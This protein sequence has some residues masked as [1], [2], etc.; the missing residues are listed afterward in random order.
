M[1]FVVTITVPR[2][3]ESTPAYWHVRVHSDASGATWVRRMMPI[4]DGYGAFWFARDPE[5]IESEPLL[6]AL[7]TA[8]APALQAVHDGIVGRRPTADVAE[9]GRYLFD[10]LIGDTIWRAI[11]SEAAAAHEDIELALCWDWSNRSLSRL[12]WEMMATADQFLAGGYVEGTRVHE[13]AVTRVVPETPWAGRPARTVPRILF[14]VGTSLL[15]GTIRAGS[16]IIDILQRPGRESDIQWQLIEEASPSLVEQHVK[17]FAPDVVHFVC[18][19]GVDATSGEG[20]LELRPDP[21]RSDSQF[22]A[23]QI[24]TWLRAAGSMPAMVVLSACESG[25]AALGP[26]HMSPLAAALVMQGTPVVIG[27]SGRISDLA[28]RLFTRRFAQA[29]IGA[30]HPETLVKATALGRRAAFAM[31]NDPRASV[32]WGFPTVFLSS[33]VNHAYTPAVAPPTGAV[34]VESRLMPYEL[35]RTP[36]FCGRREFFDAFRELMRDGTGALVAFVDSERKGFGRTRLLEALTIAGV[37]EG[38]IPCLVAAREGR[39]RAPRDAYELGRLVDEA[40]ETARA[41]LA[42]PTRQERPWLQLEQYVDGWVELQALPATLRRALQKGTRPGDRVVTD[43]AVTVAL[44]E[45][46]AALMQTARALRPNLIG[47]RSRAVVL[48]DDVHDYIDVLDK[49]VGDKLGTFGFGSQS[50]DNEAGQTTGGPVPIVFTLSTPTARR[51]FVDPIVQGRTGVRAL[52][53]GP[54]RREKGFREDM[55]VYRRFLLHTAMQLGGHHEPVP[56]VMDYD[57]E[58]AIVEKYE[59]RYEKWLDAIPADLEDK[60]FRMI[61]DEASGDKF[62]KAADDAALVRELQKERT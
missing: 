7:S 55:L 17:E 45:Q 49:V 42:L 19:G 30:D 15:D 20:F 35:R 2:D 13:V 39:W 12:H 58:K 54:F 61:S 24:A 16:E 27:M 43:A 31:G 46:L 14:V 48:L 44:E 6:S 62:L 1:R 29:L 38:H 22:G 51:V 3:T 5:S 36:V 10:V 41:S 59:Q 56:W 52:K 50:I 28:C 25:G 11:A 4:D 26:H 33:H 37:M 32:D 18:H 40:M 57:V 60:P 8:P 53:L 23:H 34:T 47:S 21:G 9:Y